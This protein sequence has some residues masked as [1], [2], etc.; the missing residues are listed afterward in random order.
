MRQAMR[1][2]SALLPILPAS[3]LHKKSKERVNPRPKKGEKL[4]DQ[5]RLTPSARPASIHLI[6]LAPSPSGK[7]ADCKSAIPGSN[8]GGAFLLFP[9]AS[10]CNFVRIGADRLTQL[11]T[12]GDRSF[13]LFP[14]FSANRCDL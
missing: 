11:R 9:G 4:P 6:N 1:R 7:A 8:P 13:R 5:V 3:D 14:T 2:A 12:Y 10:W